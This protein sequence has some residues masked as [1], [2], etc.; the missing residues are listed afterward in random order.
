MALL[1]STSS[2]SYKIN[3]TYG[4]Y[5]GFG[6]IHSRRSISVPYASV[7]TVLFC[8]VSS[9]TRTYLDHEA[10]LERRAS[11]MEKTLPIIL[12][13]CWSTALRGTGMHVA[14]VKISQPTWNTMAIS[15]LLRNILEVTKG[16]SVF[17]FCAHKIY[18]QILEY[19]RAVTVL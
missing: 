16:V 10:P 3:Q 1:Y 8:S 15:N 4:A 2:S 12:D 14:S 6:N 17:F 11:V 19:L 9:T 7:A 18:D 5:A 13:R